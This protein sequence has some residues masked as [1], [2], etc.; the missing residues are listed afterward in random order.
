MLHAIL[1]DLDNTM[2]L[3]DERSYFEQYFA[4]ISPEFSDLF[5]PDEF[6]ERY[7]RSARSLKENTGAVSNRD[8]FLENFCNGNAC[9]GEELWRRF[10]RFY[11]DGHN[12]IRVDASIPNGLKGVLVALRR[13]GLKRVI[14][15]NPVF[16]AVAQKGRLAWGDIDPDQ[17]DFFTEI[18]NMSFVK[19]RIGYY[20]QICQKIGEP[21][22]A[23]LMVGNDLQNDM[24]AKRAGLK[25]YLTCEGEGSDAVSLS[26]TDDERSRLPKIPVPDFSGP[27]A[28]VT[29]AV[30]KLMGG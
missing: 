27:F 23:C 20:R 22:G 28:G 3:F 8:F 25:T 24:V 29:R 15:S 4:E 26:L 2:V 12:R 7:L 5:A 18:E 11:G 13:S 16:P 30:E 19:P 10:M 6:R 17:F 9:Q 21:P 1:L 14:A